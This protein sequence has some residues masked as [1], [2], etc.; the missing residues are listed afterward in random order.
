MQPRSVDALTNSH[1]QAREESS[2]TEEVHHGP[3]HFWLAQ[4]PDVLEVRRIDCRCPIEGVIFTSGDYL[5]RIGR[6]FAL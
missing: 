2:T 4:A 3:G 5:V 6:Y 1:A